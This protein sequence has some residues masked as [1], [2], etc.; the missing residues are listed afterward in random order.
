MAVPNVLHPVDEAV[1][2]V[3]PCPLGES[4]TDGGSHRLIGQSAD[5]RWTENDP[6]DQEEGHEAGDDAPPPVVRCFE[7]PGTT[8]GPVGRSVDRLVQLARSERTTRRR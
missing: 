6:D 5:Q 7:V 8:S 2:T 1:P 3:R 4:S